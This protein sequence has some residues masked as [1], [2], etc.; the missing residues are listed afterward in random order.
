MRDLHGGRFGLGWDLDRIRYR[1]CSP[2]GTDRIG[3]HRLLGR[4]CRWHRSS[5]IL[6]VCQ[7]RV[8]ARYSEGGVV[9]A[10]D[11]L[12]RTSLGL[13]RSIPSDPGKPLT[14]MFK[15][16]SILA[17]NAIGA[18]HILSVPHFHLHILANR[19]GLTRMIQRN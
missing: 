15:V 8:L 12:M 2:T 14:N 18:Y 7:L 9:S 1:R 13:R 6:R 19:R 17:V 11:I 5:R 3:F 4:C 16:R 10:V